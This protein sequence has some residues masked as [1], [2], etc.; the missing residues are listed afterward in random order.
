MAYRERAFVG[1][2]PQ[3]PY[4]AGFA[5]LLEAA[6]TRARQPGFLED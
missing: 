4:G 3:R 2:N 5:D 6:S 1:G